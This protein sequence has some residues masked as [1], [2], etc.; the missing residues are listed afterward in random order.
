MMIEMETRTAPI[1][2][3]RY[4]AK[5]TGR[6]R[7]GLCLSPRAAAE[8]FFQCNPTARKCE[9]QEMHLDDLDDPS[10]LRVRCTIRLG[11]GTIWPLTW[12]ATPKTVGTLPAD[13]V[14]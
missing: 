12:T 3:K 13:P 7:G 10:S 11:G 1:E 8:S 9:V 2:H 6:T 14:P 5:G 4:R